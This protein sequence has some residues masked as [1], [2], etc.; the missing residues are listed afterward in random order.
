MSLPHLG[1]QL[2]KTKDFFDEKFVN[3]FLVEN[4]FIYFLVK[5]TFH[6]FSSKINTFSFAHFFIKVEFELLVHLLA[7]NFL[8]VSRKK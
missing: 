1:Y 2:N 4:F 7:G 8:V 6:I 5:K 3:F